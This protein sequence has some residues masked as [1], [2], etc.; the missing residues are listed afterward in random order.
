VKEIS[1]ELDAS[2]DL[3]TKDEAMQLKAE[4]LKDV[5]DRME[6]VIEKMTKDL[7]LFPEIPACN[8][9]VSEMR[10]VYEDVDQK[11]GSA[12]EAPVEIAV[13]RG[14]TKGTKP[15]EVDM[16]KVADRLE[17]M[18]MWL[19]DKP[20]QIAWKQESTDVEEIPDIPLA[21]LPEELEDLV[22]ELM[23]QQASLGPEAQDAASNVLF[24][25]LPAGWGVSDGPMPSFGAKGK[26][27]NTKPNDMEMTGRSGAGREGKADG[28]VVENF[29]KDLEG[30]PTE[31]RRTCDPFQSGQVQ[32]ENPNS[33]ARATGGGKQSGIGGEGGLSG[34]APPRNEL[35]LRDLQRRQA[36]LRRRTENLYTKA[37]LLYL[38]SGELDRAVLLMHKADRQVREGDFRGFAETRQRILHALH[39]TKQSLAGGE[40]VALDPRYKLPARMKKVIHDAR[41]EAVPPEFEE[42]VS[43]YYKAIAAGIV[44]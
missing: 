26:S 14:E 12:D 36:G 5:R 25:D 39:N 24:P 10:E 8:E 7:S 44:K 13:D 30:T 28:E 17:D 23:D 11:P 22:G 21:D 4:E 20:D 2:R 3:R 40:G 35:N 38:P 34:K 1:K 16:E 6:D 18:E 43:E 27:G 29:A 37:S 41:D 32:E 33:Q 15:E 42:M 19:E 9:M 31:A